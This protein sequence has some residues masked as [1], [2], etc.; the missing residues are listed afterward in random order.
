MFMLS[1]ELVSACKCTD[2]TTSHPV[3]VLVLGIGYR[4]G[5]KY[6]VLGAKLSI[7]VTLMCTTLLI[8]HKLSLTL[9]CVAYLPIGLT[10]K[11]SYFI[12]THFQYRTVN[13]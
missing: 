5:P 11:L 8:M 1:I 10:E 13:N 9:I 6:W 2:F 12:I 4:Q 3:S 7:V